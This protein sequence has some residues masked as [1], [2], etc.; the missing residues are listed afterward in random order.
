MAAQVVVGRAAVA[1]PRVVVEPVRAVVEP[2]ELVTG[3][4]VRRKVGVRWPLPPLPPPLPPPRR[5]L[6]V[7]W[8]LAAGALLLLGVGLAASTHGPADKPGVPRSEEPPVAS[9]TV[10]QLQKLPPNSAVT[11]T[12]ESPGPVTVIG[13]LTWQTATASSRYGWKD[14]KAYCRDLML[15]AYSDWRLPTK[16]EL[17][18]T[19]ANAGSTC[20]QIL[21]PL[22]DTTDCDYY[23]S[24]TRASRQS[25]ATIVGFFFGAGTTTNDIS[26]GYKVRCV[27]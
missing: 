12:R 17:Q 8:V 10:P 14:A 15:G 11:A 18:A 26:H 23:W 22:R 16:E 9:V 6:G 2:V 24:S 7:R 3:A 20:P 13:P 19:I 25:S 21:A 4:A 5:K 1:G 27:R